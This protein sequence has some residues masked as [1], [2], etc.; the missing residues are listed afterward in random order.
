MSSQDLNE[1]LSLALG[2][3]LKTHR[4]TNDKKQKDLAQ[5]LHIDER[6]LRRWE[7]GQVSQRV[8][9][10]RRIADVLGIEYEK[11]GITPSTYMPFTLEQVNSLVEQTWFLIQEGQYVEG[12]QFIEKLIHDLTLQ[13]H[14]EDSILLRGLASA[15]HVAGHITS[16][17]SRTEKVPEAL[18][19]FHEVEEI[20]R[21]LDD[22]TFL[23]IALTYQ[24]DMLRRQGKVHEAIEYLEAARDTAPQADAEA[25]GNGL[26]LLARAYAG[27]NDMQG[28]EQTMAQSEELSIDAANYTGSA[29]GFYSLGAV[30]EEYA[31]TYGWL[32]K[33]AKAM[34]YLDL[35][36]KNL[37]SN[38]HWSLVL[39]TAR[40]MTLVRGED[41]R[42]GGKL[43]RDAA[44]LCLQSGNNRMLERVY[45]I[46]N[47]LESFARDVGQVTNS[48][49]AVLNGSIERFY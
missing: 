35:A 40:A 30:Y 25:R 20:A 17:G 45:S 32:G 43:A 12:R 39:M 41:I 11:L 3:A 19:H 5:E 9:D 4:L 21:I 38:M 44:I 28:F 33:T 16:E 7:S 14:S 13:V 6:T 37:P 8:D 31:K 46:Q 47:Y 18:R 42:E 15:H 23:N 34:D 48:L 49:R 36:E 29:H 10:L 27:N 24:G 1:R 2:Y 22:Q 26:Q